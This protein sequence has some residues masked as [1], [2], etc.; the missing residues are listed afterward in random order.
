MVVSFA[1]KRAIHD[2]DANLILAVKPS[3]TRDTQDGYA[4][5]AFRPPSLFMKLFLLFWSATPA[6]KKNS[7]LLLSLG[8]VIRYSIL[9]RAAP[10][11]PC[12]SRFT[13]PGNFRRCG[14][15][16][17]GCRKG[18]AWCRRKARCEY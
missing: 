7:S 5:I 6:G 4:V 3:T 16:F 15:K 12:R 10:P 1:R 18:A 9:D 13:I 11:R 17:E 14:S 8:Q 2:A